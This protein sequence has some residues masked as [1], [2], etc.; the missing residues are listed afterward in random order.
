M[1]P[2]PTSHRK[3]ALLALV[4]LICLS[5]FGLGP[6]G[7][8]H[9][10]QGLES[11]PAA[12][13]IG[14]VK[15]TLIPIVG[16]VPVG[17]SGCPGVRPGA[18]I[19]TSNL[20]GGGHCT[21][22]FLFSGSDGNRYAG[23]AAH[24]VP[25]FYDPLGTPTPASEQTWAG[26]SGPEVRDN[27]GSPIGTFAY[28]FLGTAGQKPFDFALIRLNAFGQSVSS[29]QM[30][31]F[32][33]PTAINTDTTTERTIF[34]HYGQ[35]AGIGL[36]V[37]ARTALSIFGMPDA[38]HVFVQGVAVPGDSGSPI[39]SVDGRAVGVITTMGFKA[40]LSGPTEAGDVGVL[41][42]GHMVHRAGSKIGITLTLLTS[43]LAS[44]L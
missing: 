22:N 35:G 41:R 12:L 10:G 28:A 26:S 11:S 34:R 25:G 17:V 18:S 16:D 24:C 27:T 8:D 43:S 30:C 42:L 6:A 37:P 31:H 36:A 38:E 29:P 40:N 4:G 32:G 3:Q 5:Q 7:A 20:Q 2:L 14:G 13:D 33:G 23:T 39:I 9:A 21:L 15:C 19:D 1:T 44:A